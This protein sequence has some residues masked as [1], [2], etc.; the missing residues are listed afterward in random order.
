MVVAN[1]NCLEICDSD[2]L[3]YIGHMEMGKSAF[4]RQK[5]RLRID[6]DETGLMG[7]NCGIC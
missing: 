6:S 2:I 4:R 3:M 7:G 5:E 1:G